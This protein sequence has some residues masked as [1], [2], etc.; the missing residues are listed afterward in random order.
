MKF[1]TGSLPGLYNF[2]AG[3][4]RMVQEAI[5]QK[6][7]YTGVFSYEADIT[8]DP[9][10]GGYDEPVAVLIGPECVSACDGLALLLKSSGR[11]TMIGEPSNGTGAGLLG[12]APYKPEPWRDNYGVLSLVLPNSLFGFPGK[13]GRYV[14]PEDDAYIEFNAENRPTQPNVAFAGS[15]DDYL[16]N[17]RSIFA[18]AIE[19]IDQQAPR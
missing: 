10:I 14:Y 5:K 12:I 16:G 7:P 15:L 9:A 13:V 4:V 1:R 18:K 3:A 11:V 19:V 2:D 6:K 8:A 17:S